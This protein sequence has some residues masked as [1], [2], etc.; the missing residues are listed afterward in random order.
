[1]GGSLCRFGRLRLAGGLGLARVGVRRS[2]V[3]SRGG[4]LRRL[5]RGGREGA[6]LVCRV[7]G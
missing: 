2:S 4:F 7:I 1:M 6:V 5:D 3:G